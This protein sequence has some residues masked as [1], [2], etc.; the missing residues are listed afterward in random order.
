MTSDPPEPK[1]RDVMDPPDCIDRPLDEYD[2]Q[3]RKPRDRTD[4]PEPEFAKMIRESVARFEEVI[5]GL[6]E[7]K[8][9]ASK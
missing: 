1:Q 7:T 3:A 5:R 9:N 4:K 6:T 8:P 2:E